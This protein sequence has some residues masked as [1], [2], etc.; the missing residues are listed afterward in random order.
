CEKS[1][2][3]QTVGVRR[4]ATVAMEVLFRVGQDAMVNE[5]TDFEKML[6]RKEWPAGEECTGVGPPREE[7]KKEEEENKGKDEKVDD[8]KEGVE[9]VKDVLEDAIENV[10][11][12][13]KETEKGEE[14]G[15]DVDVEDAETADDPEATDD[16]EV[17]E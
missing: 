4:K 12:T 17:T 7:P 8:V 6:W 10:N 13:Q 9:A 5:R 11:G 15:E 1:A 14:D 2:T 16:T 3:A